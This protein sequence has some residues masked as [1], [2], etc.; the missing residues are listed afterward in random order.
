M[1]ICK[2]IHEIFY[3]S[4]SCCTMIKLYHIK[5]T[6]HRCPYFYSRISFYFF[7]VNNWPWKAKNWT[8]KFYLRTEKWY[9]TLKKSTNVFFVKIYKRQNDKQ[10][11]RKKLQ[12]TKLQATGFYDVSGRNCKVE[13]LKHCFFVCFLKIFYGNINGIFSSGKFWMQLLKS[14]KKESEIVKN[15]STQSKAH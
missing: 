4:S 13:T 9:Q 14:I 11:V 6:F 10:Q 5:I 12:T 8:G 2:A 1:P 7:A 15:L 3:V